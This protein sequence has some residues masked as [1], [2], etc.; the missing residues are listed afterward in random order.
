MS[1]ISINK[2]TFQL[3][4]PFAPRPPVSSH[5]DGY[6]RELSSF[7]LA[8]LIERVSMAL[9]TE[10][11]G[12]KVDPYVREHPERVFAARFNASTGALAANYPN[13]TSVLYT[14]KSDLPAAIA[15][16]PAIRVLEFDHHSGLKKLPDAMVRMAGRLQAL[17]LVNLPFID[18]GC[19]GEL[20]ELRYLRLYG[21]VDVTNLDAL[22]SLDQLEELH[23]DG[24]SQIPEIPS[25]LARLPALQRLQLRIHDDT[26][27]SI[28]AALE[29]V[30]V[31]V[32]ESPHRTALPRELATMPRLRELELS[33]FGLTDRRM[34]AELPE[35]EALAMSNYPSIALLPEARAMSND[36]AVALPEELGELGNLEYLD[37]ARPEALEATSSFACLGRLQKLRRLSCQSW[38]LAELP[39][40]FAR[41]AALEEIDLSFCSD[42]RNIDAIGA[43]P[44]LKIVDLCG[45]KNV[46]PRPLCQL[47][48][49]ELVNL[50]LTAA[51]IAPLAHH[52][53]LRAIQIHPDLLSAES[54]DSFQIIE[55]TELA[56][57][58]VRERE[59]QSE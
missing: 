22:G 45:S 28:L 17:S 52:P 7:S 34:L 12:K 38:P 59:A 49:L 25:V 33:M 6:R 55:E 14:G 50:R 15:D 40:E 16:H 31:L 48:R 11:K 35:L 10:H 44:N 46:D 41:L 29:S 37:L 56:V 39:A 4:D 9:V 8:E 5:P 18:L 58:R 1:V 47:P 27:T 20:R 53:S 2:P 51:D 42:L 13:L 26:D 32:L 36:P 3:W 43:L 30:K 21:Y 57:P 23:L 19:I 54:L 24:L